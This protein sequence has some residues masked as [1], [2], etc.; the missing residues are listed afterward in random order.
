MDSAWLAVL[1]EKSYLFPSGWPLS[2]WAVN[3]AY[4]V[5]LILIIVAVSPGPGQQPCVRAIANA[6]NLA[7]ISHSA[8]WRGQA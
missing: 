2:V 8:R 5:V 4:P 6:R 7:R 1:A 3:L